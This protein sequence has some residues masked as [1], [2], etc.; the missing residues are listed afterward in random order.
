MYFRFS[1]ESTD[2]G[3]A[4]VS[5]GISPCHYQKVD[6]MTRFYLFA[7]SFLL[8]T[9]TWA[10]TDADLG[11][12]S[13]AV[14]VFSGTTVG[15]SNNIDTYSTANSAE[16]YDQDIIYRFAVASPGVLTLLSNDPD[17]NSGI[18]ND[19]FLLSSLTTTTSVVN[20]TTV[21]MAQAIGAN[22]ADQ[23]VTVSGSWDVP[24][25]GTYF[26]AI[27]AYRGNLFA[28]G[29]PAT[30]RAGAFSGSLSF[31]ATAVPE[32]TTALLLCAG[33]FAAV[34]GALQQRQNKQTG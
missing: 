28:T 23:L 25:A 12:I 7:A 29:T 18:D 30:G 27:D 9:A 1:T 16:I 26:L 21:R 13:G 10:Q 14:Q 6:F 22:S 2:N 34:V 11:T 5:A 8:A 19:F 24:V 17:S 15:A 3:I 20:G 33:T 4:G 32:P 31:A